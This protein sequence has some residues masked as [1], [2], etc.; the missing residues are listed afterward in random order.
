MAIVGSTGPRFTSVRAAPG[1]HR[2]AYGR[3]ERRHPLPAGG[4][5]VI[6]DVHQAR[7]PGQRLD[8]GRCRVIDVDEAGD[9]VIGDQRPARA[10]AALLPRGSYH[11]SGP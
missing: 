11:V 5:L 8:R 10:S 1:Q 6:A 7:R 9:I 3:I 2:R 4:R